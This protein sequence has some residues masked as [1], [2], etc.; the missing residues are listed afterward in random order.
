MK[1]LTVEEFAAQTASAAPVP[2]GG[3]IAAISGALG[4]ALAGM[5]A[6]LTIGKKKYAEFDEE[7]KVIADEAERLRNMLL[8]D[9]QRDSTSFSD[10]MTAMKLPKETEHQKEVRTKKMQTGL[11]KAATV[12][13]EI[14]CHAYKIMNLAE[15]VVDNGNKNAVTDG[16]VAAMMSRT[17]VLSALL[18]TK[19]NL[20][21]I[22]D[23]EFVERMTSNVK[24][25]EEKVK[26][27]EV[28]VLSKSPY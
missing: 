27:Y 23:E 16:L 4:A 9:I 12:P 21:S 2:G 3:S 7:M 19:I 8:D 28:K 24:D 11:K 20:A 18:N 1:N 22:K 13:F 14:A 6:N 17:A 10:V 26:A 15:K 5:V 25:L